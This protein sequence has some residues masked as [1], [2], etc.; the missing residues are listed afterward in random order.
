MTTGG[1]LQQ[2]G[3]SDR[4][5]AEAVNAW[6]RTVFG[7]PRR[8]AEL[9]TGVAVND[10]VLR[11][12]VTQVVRR[13]LRERRAPADE[14]QPT[15][16]RLDPSRL[17]PFAY[18]QESLRA[19]S[20]YTARCG[21]CSGGG[22][23]SCGQCGGD[24]RA[25][26][27]NCYG[28]GKQRSEKTNRPIK[29]KT[30]KG[31][32]DVACVTCDESGRV[33]CG[34]CRGSGHERAWLAY[35]ES[36][37]WLAAVGPSSPVVVAHRALGE[38]RPL[39][40]EELTAF[41]VTGSA[42]A[43][44]PLDASVL[45]PDDHAFIA[46]RARIDQRL[47]RI[48]HQQFLRLAVVRRDATYE[49]CGTEGTLVLSGTPLAGARTAAA[50]RPIRRR[51]IVWGV[52]FVLLV[53]AL[54]GLRSAV[55][56][57]AS[58][59]FASARQWTAGLWAFSALLAVPALGGLLR[60][61]RGGFRKHRFRGYEKGFAAVALVAAV[62]MAGLG[63]FIRPT[64]GELRSALSAG[65]TGRAR[66]VIDA[67]KETEGARGAVSEAEDAVMLAEAD[68]ASTD[69]RLELLD[70]VAARSGTKAAEAAQTARRV[71]EDEIRRLIAAEKSTE[72]IA[73]VARWF[74]PNGPRDPDVL[75]L[76][77][78][79]H[80]VAAKQCADDP[81]RYAARAA[82]ESSLTT[83]AR[84]AAV[85]EARAQL[86]ASLTAEPPSAGALERL[87]HFRTLGEVAEKTRDV[88]IADANLAEIARAASERAVTERSKVAIIGAEKP[89]AA[90]LLGELRDRDGGIAVATFDAVDVHAV[91][92]NKGRVRGLYAVGHSAEHSSQGRT[93][94]A[95]VA[96]RLGSQAVGRS[97]EVR[98]PSE[99]T[100][101]NVRWS[102]GKVRIVARWYD[103]ALRELRI[104]DAEP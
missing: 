102:E 92:D 81:C 82:A 101:S 72:A 52:L 74:P 84:A 57:G 53:L 13:D 54:A 41:A 62:A 24:G 58:A 67:L 76:L 8:L 20:E 50:V 19:A 77:A 87:Q 65:D 32:G 27:S 36:S 7:A 15:P 93:I 69:A 104:G 61:W 70:K 79:A 97:V 31:K 14:R 34:T 44:G 49:M 48:T 46:E 37:R 59:Y 66:E 86:T 2:S 21:T 39:R 91:F 17:D 103:G 68:K 89:V 38:A 47:E 18:S 42:E 98:N 60:A 45:T 80:D 30:C 88:A 11:R 10:E 1:P 55:L 43:R 28:T 83:P 9:V 75:E 71:R 26:C 90:E 22:Q 94:D 96:S 56:G 3:A 63:A 29:C 25:R 5:V 73:A 12:I 23:V 95:L 64:L 40:V 16:A 51:L 78:Q 99:E 6:G 35:E 100:I 85:S 4:A 33:T